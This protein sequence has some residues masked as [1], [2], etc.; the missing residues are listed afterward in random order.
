MMKHTLIA[1]A[2]AS[3]TLLAVLSVSAATDATKAGQSPDQVACDFGAFVNEN[4]PKGLNVR[5]GPNA[6]SKILGTFPSNIVIDKE[7]AIVDRFAV[8]VLASKNGW[9]LVEP[10]WNGARRMKNVY[11]MPRENEGA[12]KKLAKSSYKGRGWVSGRKLT[13]IAQ[14]DSALLSPDD[15]A[16]KAFSLGSYTIGGSIGHNPSELIACEGQWAQLEYKVSDDLLADPAFLDFLKLD[17]KAAVGTTK[18]RIRGW[19]NKVCPLQHQDC[20][21]NFWDESRAQPKTTR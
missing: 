13:L 17:P 9:F 16:G 11:V 21:S 15:K 18:N 6:A 10:M 20:P 14:R 19:V 1:S 5:A 7:V 3:S 2:I 8:N 12:M 4:D